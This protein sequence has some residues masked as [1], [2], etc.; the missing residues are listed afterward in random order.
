MLH[1]SK[2]IHSGKRGILNGVFKYISEILL[3]PFDMFLEV[4]RTVN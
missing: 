4:L 3:K 2:K 1:R